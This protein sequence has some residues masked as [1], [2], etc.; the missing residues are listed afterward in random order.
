M[1]DVLMKVNIKTPA[2]FTRSSKQP[3]IRKLEVRK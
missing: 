3:K 2:V 1:N